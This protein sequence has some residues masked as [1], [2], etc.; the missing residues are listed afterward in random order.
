MRRSLLI[1]GMILSLAACATPQPKTPAVRLGNP[2]SDA[3]DALRKG[4]STY[5]GIL[6]DQIRLPG[7]LISAADESDRT[8]R[9]FSRRS[10]G[11][12]RSGWADQRDSL[13]VYAAAYNAMIHEAR[14]R[15]TRPVP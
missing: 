8:I 10:V 12:S 2:V 5:L 15:G 4:D 14:Y 3:R 9:V 13:T 1:A 7:L 11:L 6:D